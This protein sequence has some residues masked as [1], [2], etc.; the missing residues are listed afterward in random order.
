MRRLLALLGLTLFVAA[1]LA[2][3]AQAQELVPRCVL[4]PDLDGHVWKVCH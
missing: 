3:P 2:G 1:G 4:V